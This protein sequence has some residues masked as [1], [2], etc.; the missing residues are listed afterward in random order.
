MQSQSQLTSSFANRILTWFDSHGR[1]DLPWQ[2]GKTPYSVWVSEIMLQ[3]TQVKTVIP[4]Y[5]KFMLRF[6]DILSLANAPQDEVL[7]HWT[8]LGYYARARNL[9]KAAQVIRDEYGGVFPPD[10]NDVVALPGIGRST[11]GA[12]LSLACGQH[13][14]ILDGNVKRVLA[15]YF[16][17]DG[18]PGKK[19]VEQA[20][21][22]YADS[23]TPSSR[24]GDYT[25][26]MMDMGA[27]IC[28]RSKP[29]CDNCPLQ[30]SCLAF[31]QGRQSELPGKKPKKD[32]PVR[33]TVML[34]PMWQSQVLIYQ[35]PSTGLWGGLWGFYEAD[36]LEA[37][38]KTAQQLGL[39]DYTRV[40]LEPFR[41][42]FS[43]FHLDIQPVILQLAQPTS[44]QINEKQQI[45]YD[46]LNQPNVGLAAPTKKLLTVCQTQL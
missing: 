29:K 17:V 13:H 42:T 45:W 1:K 2:Q 10:I 19:D 26:A 38:D 7:H 5:Q 36:T 44:L 43:H 39:S 15:R 24:T 46:L 32:I 3:Q 33:T 21:W 14:S 37:L 27:T 16:A 22:Q 23:L 9:Q 20:L 34:I 6:P 40:T 41:H 18:W 35:R 28:T 31:A 4:Y 30:Q 12:V 25:Q 11:A 8:G